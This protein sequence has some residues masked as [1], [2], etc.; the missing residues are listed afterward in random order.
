MAF[1]M[2]G[3]L[4]L[5]EAAAATTVTLLEPLDVVRWSCPTSSSARS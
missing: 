2:A 1:Q 5:R 4:A 3:S